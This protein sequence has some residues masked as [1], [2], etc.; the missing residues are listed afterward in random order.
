[1]IQIYMQQTLT[2]MNVVD[3]PA[4]EKIF[5][6]IKATKEG[7]QYIIVTP[8]ENEQENRSTT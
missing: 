2:L 4:L 3:R 5:G 6:T 8:Q 7:I 1:M